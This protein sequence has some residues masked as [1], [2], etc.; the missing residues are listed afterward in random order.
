MDVDCAYLQRTEKAFV[1]GGKDDDTVNGIKA[2][3]G[4]RDEANDLDLLSTVAWCNDARQALRDAEERGHGRSCLVVMFP[5]GY[6]RIETADSL[7]LSECRACSTLVGVMERSGTSAWGRAT[8][9]TL[10]L[11]WSRCRSSVLATLPKD[12]FQMLCSDYVMRNED[13]WLSHMERR[14]LC[15]ECHWIDEDMVEEPTPACLALLYAP[16]DESILVLKLL[17]IITFMIDHGYD[18]LVFGVDRSFDYRILAILKEH[19]APLDCWGKG[20]GKLRHI[21]FALGYENCHNFR[22]SWHSAYV[23]EKANAKC[24]LQ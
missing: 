15:A 19:C 24:A 12:V 11:I 22:E 4:L 8:V 6:D 7:F 18:S 1:V 3:F 20:E 16:I 14:V 5:P 2:R 9:R 21:T 23:P 17:L 13:E 10:I